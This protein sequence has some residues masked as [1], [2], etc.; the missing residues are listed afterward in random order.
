MQ[1]N[2]FTTNHPSTLTAPP[3]RGRPPRS[4]P[5]PFP[6]S[7]PLARLLPNPF[8]QLPVSSHFPFPGKCPP[9]FP[10]CRRHRGICVSWVFLTQQPPARLQSTSPPRNGL[11]GWLAPLPRSGLASGLRASSL[12]GW[13]AINCGCLLPEEPRWHVTRALAGPRLRHIAHEDSSRCGRFACAPSSPESSR[14]PPYLSAPNGLAPWPC[15][16][17]SSRNAGC[18]RPS[19][20]ANTSRDDSARQLRAPLCGGQRR[21]G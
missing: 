19:A 1:M 10:P 18:S 7:P 17:S 4:T 9:A 12:A 5:C 21:T 2:A 13:S 3:D 15:D 8:Q 16:S 11:P 6:R 14:P 20:S